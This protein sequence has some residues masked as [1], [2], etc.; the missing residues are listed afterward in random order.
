MQRN[1]S[2]GYTALAMAI[3]QVGV[4]MA[5]WLINAAAPELPV[6]SLL[7]Q[8][9]IRWFFGQFVTN[10]Q[11]EYLIWI[12]LS[13]IAY[14]CITKSRIVSYVL[15]HERH[16]YRERLGMRLAIVEL[17]VFIGF[18]IALTLIPHAVL[19]SVTG[20]LFPSSFSK[21]II[22]VVC[23]ILGNCSLTYGWISGTLKDISDIYVAMTSGLSSAAWIIPLYIFFMQL[24]YSVTFVFIPLFSV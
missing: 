5:S 19:L 23:F 22:P 21:S 1:K 12:I 4:I 14:G 10:M 16:T 15:C 2:L 24:Y 20:H 18:M 6:R 17:I 13:A 3:M 11:S 8:T 9:G 7:S